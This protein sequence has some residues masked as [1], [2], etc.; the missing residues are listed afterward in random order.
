[1]LFLCAQYKYCSLYNCT[2][3]RTTTQRYSTCREFGSK[4]TFAYDLDSVH[5]RFCFPSNSFSTLQ[6]VNYYTIIILTSI[7]GQFKTSSAVENNLQQETTE[8]EGCF[9]TPAQSVSANP[10]HSRNC[11]NC[12]PH[13]HV[14]GVKQEVR[15]QF[16]RAEGLCDLVTYEHRVYGFSANRY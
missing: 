14:D 4:N 6:L 10:T 2:E 11:V 12:S 7:W 16:L 3:Q 8:V 9:Q 13:K 15:S 5:L 1:M